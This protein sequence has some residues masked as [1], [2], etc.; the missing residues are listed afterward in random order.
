MALSAASIYVY[1]KSSAL[2]SGRATVAAL[3]GAGASIV[4]LATLTEYA[5][6]WNLGID[7]LILPVTGAD[8][9]S[10]TPGRMAA[11]TALCLLLI[12]AGLAALRVRRAWSIALAQFLLCLSLGVTLTA[13]LGYAYGVIPMV[14]LGHGFQIAFPA[15]LCLALLSVAGLLVDP[16]NGWVTF[17]FS[18]HAGGRMARRLLPFAFVVPL[19]LGGL[20]ATTE[21]YG[22]SAA[23]QT[24]LVAVTA[25]IVSAI[26]I[27]LTARSLNETD[28]ERELVVRER[29]AAA[30][31]VKSLQGLLPICSYC[32]KVR[33]EADYW[34][35]VESYLAS[36]TGRELTHSICPSCLESEMEKVV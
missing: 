25:M 4:G 31:E 12:G 18:P 11:V 28:I 19:A 16:S 9:L 24:A 3:L 14:G 21:I 7:E 32:K 34:N 20:H 5:Y 35:E 17:L 29:E 22:A 15:A 13:F 30:A 27:W 8:R 23:I 10:T 2:W 1:G 36:N 6:K 26:L 33:N